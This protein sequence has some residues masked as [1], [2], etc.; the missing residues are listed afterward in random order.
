MGTLRKFNLPPL[1]EK[2]NVCNFVETGTGKGESL[3]YAQQITQFEH[4]YS[5]EYS[6]LLAS[7]AAIKFKSDNRIM[8]F[9][10]ESK[11]ILEGVLN[12]LPE[13]QPI[14]FW[15]DAHFP[16]DKD[17]D[18]YQDGSFQ[19]DQIIPLEAEL[20]II[21]DS[22][23]HSKDIILCDDLRIYLKGNYE[24]GNVPWKSEGNVDF[25]YKLFDKSHNIKL[26]NDHEG[27]IELYPKK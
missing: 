13:D 27:Y 19:K 12:F 16:G 24:H 6:P 11:N 2:Y 18:K 20:E 14:L 4:L 5:I 1:I 26:S 25:I 9:N 17:R 21:R 3:E 10:G 22:R 7:E 8:I 23:P 15:L